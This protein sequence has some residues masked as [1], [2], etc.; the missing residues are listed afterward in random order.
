MAH[1]EKRPRRTRGLG[2]AMRT[3]GSADGTEPGFGR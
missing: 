1:H 2:W 3:P